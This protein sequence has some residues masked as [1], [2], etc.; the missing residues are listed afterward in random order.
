LHVKDAHNNR[1]KAAPQPPIIGSDPLPPRLTAEQKE[2]PMATRKYLRIGYILVALTAVMALG[3]TQFQWPTD[4]GTAGAP[5]PPETVKPVVAI[6]PTLDWQTAIA[7]VAKETIPAVVHINVTERREISN[8]MLPFGNDPF[9]HFFFNGSPVPRK[10][11]QELRGLGTGM[12]IDAKGNILTNNHVVAGASEITVLLADGRSYPAKVVGTDPKTDLAVIR[13]KADEKLPTV[14]FGDSDKMEVG[15]WVVAIGHPRG[16]DQTVTQGIISAKHRRGVTNPSSYQ[17]Y[18]QTDAAINPGNSG[19][20]L[21]N[22]EGQVIG[23][24]A[25]IATESGG[26]EGIGFAIPSNMAV[27]VAHELIAHGKVTRGWLGVSIHDLTPDQ[28]KSMHRED[29]NG[30]L[31]ADMVKDSPAEKAGLKKNDLIITYRGVPVADA[32]DLQSRVGDTPVG[33]KT[34]MT[35]VRDGKTIDLT[36]TIGNMDDAMRL[37]AA[38]VKDRLGVTIRPLTADEVQRYGLQPG[39]G[40]AIASMESDSLLGKAGFEKDDV[41]VAVN[42][43]PVEGVEGFVAAVKALPAHQQ[44]VLK[45]VDHRTGQSGYVQVTIG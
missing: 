20:P 45:A 34:G 18:L 41:I 15:D 8:P 25:A 24:N 42:N 26:F 32:A 35:V 13:I 5:T 28:V 1:C 12:L 19:G 31:V 7:R 39:E 38:S 4:R 17:D 3:F 6:Q 23:V 10:F 40:V 43:V 30:A 44:A 36:V 33:E 16:L 9:F 2:K 21:L 11:K 14:T 22:L 29:K 27:H 37:I